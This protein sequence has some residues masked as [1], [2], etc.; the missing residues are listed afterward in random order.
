MSGHIRRRGERSWEL[1]FELGARDPV[2]G[3]R[4]RRISSFKGTRR[5]AELELARLVTQ[6]AAGDGV[7]PT[8]STVA[9]FAERWVRDW[10]SMNLGAKS[11]ERYRQV[12]RLNITPHIGHVSI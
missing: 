4:N 7:D 2:T 1:R 12:L 5:E 8:K 6:H 3:K 10:A 9:E 11:L